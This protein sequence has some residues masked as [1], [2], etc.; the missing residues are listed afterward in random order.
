MKIKNNR[1]LHPD[2]STMFIEDGIN[3]KDRIVYIFDEIDALS[4]SK[5]IK[6]IQ[7]MLVAS[8]EPIDI[9]INSFGGDPY[10]AWAVSNF[11]TLQKDV[12]IRTHGMGAVMSAATIVFLSGDE[13][14]CYENT[15]FMFH[16][17]SSGTY[18]KYTV[19]IKDEY[20]E[21]KRLHADMCNF[22]GRYTKISAKEWFRI[23]KANDLYI[24]PQQALEM[25]IVDNILKPL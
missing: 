8:K 19:E 15:V 24:R 13:K 18:G 21:C 6:G 3:I 20:E 25:G 1:K 14:Y 7:L 9:Y 16:T 11:I 2:N 5:V 10:S 17:V 22:Y 4:V 23:L 12:L